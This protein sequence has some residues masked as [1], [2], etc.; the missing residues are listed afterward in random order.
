M[1]LHELEKLLLDAY[2]NT[3]IYKERTKRWY[4]NKIIRREFH[5]GDMVLLFNSRLKLFPEKFE[6]QM[7]WTIQ[8]ATFPYVAIEIF[9]ENSGAFKVNGQRLK[10]YFAGDPSEKKVLFDLL[11]TP[12]TK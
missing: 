6:V 3:R 1:E 9:N 8:S 10:H 5:E 2:E 4:E 7:V 12:S 11:D